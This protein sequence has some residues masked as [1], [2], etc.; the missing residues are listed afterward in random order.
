MVFIFFALR[1]HTM[2]G[3]HYRNSLGRALKRV[4]RPRFLRVGVLVLHAEETQALLWSRRAAL[5]YFQLLPPTAAAR[6]GPSTPPLRERTRQGPQGVRLPFGGI[7][8]DA[9]PRA[10]VDERAEKGHSLDRAANAEAARFP[11]TAKKEKPCAK[12]TTAHSVPEIRERPAELLAAAILRFQRVQREEAEGEAGLYARE[13]SESLFSQTPQGLAVEQL[14][15]LLHSGAWPDPDRRRGSV[16]GK[17][18]E[19]KTPTL[20]NRGWGTL[21]K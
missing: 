12:G 16:T 18:P 1:R 17:E 4:P 14:V 13:S 9:Q 21:A 10:F 19:E 11:E 5:S 2:R 6:F 8:G 15:V 20:R 7:C 3:Y